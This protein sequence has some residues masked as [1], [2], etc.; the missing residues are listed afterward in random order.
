MSGT[1]GENSK[2]SMLRSV[3]TLSCRLWMMYIMFNGCLAGLQA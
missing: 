3:S 1:S 2:L